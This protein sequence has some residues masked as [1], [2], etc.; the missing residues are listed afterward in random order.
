LAIPLMAGPAALTSVMIL[1]AEVRSRPA[2]LVVVMLVCVVVLAMCYGALR[3]AG[4]LARALGRTGV[5]VITRVL[6]ILLASLAVQYMADGIRA[7]LSA[8]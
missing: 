7:L 1:A 6:G 5:N 2:G 3:A 8:A 4:P